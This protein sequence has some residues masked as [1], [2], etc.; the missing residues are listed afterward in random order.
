M[1]VYDICPKCGGRK[2]KTSK[3]CMECI[4][5]ERNPNYIKKE[6]MDIDEGLEEY[7]K[8][9]K[10]LSYEEIVLRAEANKPRTYKQ[11]KEKQIWA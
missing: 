11:I 2:A 10:T 7:Q 8:H 9:G 6:P 1:S 3:Q 4:K 5:I